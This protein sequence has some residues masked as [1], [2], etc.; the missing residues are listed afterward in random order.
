MRCSKLLVIRFSK[1]FHTNEEYK[2]DLHERYARVE[3]SVGPF[4]HLSDGREG[5][6]LRL[7][8]CNLIINE[9]IEMHLFDSLTHPYF[10]SKD[11]IK[12]SPSQRE[13]IRE[14]DIIS[15]LCSS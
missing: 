12:Q 15:D 4:L 2:S 11:I 7:G 1:D 13:Y 6:V 9:F 3:F 10:T 8:Q 14:N 5:V